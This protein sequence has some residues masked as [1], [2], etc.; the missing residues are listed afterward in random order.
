MKISPITY[1]N[2]FKST[3]SGSNS[4]QE[5]YSPA[6]IATVAGVGCFGAGFLFDR[7]CAALF[8]LTRNIK[9]SL[10]VNG[11]VGL[12]IGAYTYVQAKNAEKAY[13]AIA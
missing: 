9:T 5:H 7:A 3:N 11:V 10:I 8:K 13:N 4:K 12:G 1:S 2:S 6:K